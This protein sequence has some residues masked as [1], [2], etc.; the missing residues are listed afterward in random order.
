[1]CIAC[2]WS[3]P[4]SHTPSHTPSV[5]V[6]PP[7]PGEPPDAAQRQCTRSTRTCTAS[8]CGLAL[9]TRRCNTHGAADPAR[10]C[11]TW[12]GFAWLGTARHCRAR[13]GMPRLGMAWHGLGTHGMGRFDWLHMGRMG[14]EMAT[15]RLLIISLVQRV[16]V[17]RGHDAPSAVYSCVALSALLSAVFAST[18]PLD[19]AQ[20]FPRCWWQLGR[21]M[22]VR[23]D[24]LST[25]RRPARCSVPQEVLACMPWC[26]RVVFKRQASARQSARRPAC[27]IDS[28]QPASHIHSHPWTEPAARQPVGQQPEPVSRPAPAIQPTGG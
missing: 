11:M 21:A 28:S 22:P 4:P 15:L 12:R 7:N 6:P 1:V 10:L 19:T 18:Q 16:V 20:S 26:S 24:T 9:W 3:S 17:V 14:L 13:L 23:R 25:H 2:P 5:V 8:V 27:K